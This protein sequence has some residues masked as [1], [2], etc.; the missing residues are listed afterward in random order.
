M[1]SYWWFWHWRLE[2]FAFMSSRGL[3]TSVLTVCPEGMCNVL[4]PALPMNLFWSLM[5]ANVPL[6]ITASLP[7]R[8]PYE[9]NSR[10]VRLEEI[11]ISDKYPNTVWCFV[12]FKNLFFFFPLSGP[13]F[14]SCTLLPDLKLTVCSA[15]TWLRRW[16]WQCC[17]LGRCDPLSRCFRG[18]VRRERSLSTEGLEPLYSEMRRDTRV[19][20]RNPT[21]CSKL[22]SE[23]THQL[24][25]KRWWAY[26][27]GLVIPGENHRIWTLNVAPEHVPFLDRQ[28]RWLF[29]PAKADGC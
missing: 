19:S 18:T 20:M 25:E 13:D 23:E 3:E 4:G 17:Q 27:R 28:H 6:V 7:L 11:W 12:Y 29:I 8:A 15:G 22:R 21:P 2:E 24:A 14:T 26:I 5:L 10:G 1:F 16:P 9:L